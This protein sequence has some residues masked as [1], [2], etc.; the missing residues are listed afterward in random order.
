MSSLIPSGH[1]PTPV[2]ARAT[3][4]AIN[5]GIH[6]RH[7][8]LNEFHQVYQRRVTYLAPHLILPIPT[9]DRPWS[10]WVKTDQDALG[11]DY[12]IEHPAEQRHVRGI[13]V[14]QT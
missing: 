7:L 10:R 14:E 1:D 2:A 8:P 4:V 12:Q 3:A 6:C 13:I 11:G 9:H 5:L